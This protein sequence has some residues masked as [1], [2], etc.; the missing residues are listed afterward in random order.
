MYIKTKEIDLIKIQTE[1]TGYG[2]ISYKKEGRFSYYRT[3]GGAEVDF[4]IEKSMR[5]CISDI[6]KHVSLLYIYT[7]EV[8]YVD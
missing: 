6:D 3:T 7:C 4:I 8:I 1:S 2:K 5:N